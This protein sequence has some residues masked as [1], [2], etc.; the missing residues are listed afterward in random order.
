MAVNKQI[1]AAI[2]MDRNVIHNELRIKGK[3]PNWPDKG[4]HL[5][6]KSNSKTD[7]SWNNAADLIINPVNNIIG[8][9][10]IRI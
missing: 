4:F 2:R 7:F 9:V 5:L 6:E 1:G 3:N 10:Q 8:M